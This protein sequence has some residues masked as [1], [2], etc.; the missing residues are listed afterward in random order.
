MTAY[1]KETFGKTRN[2]Q[3]PVPERRYDTSV[4]KTLK[5]K[6]IMLQHDVT[7]PRPYSASIRSAAPKKVAQKYQ[8]GDRWNPM[9]TA[10]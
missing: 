1:A 5:G 3:K 10:F 7:S 2:M 9:R 8:I 4:I 6:T